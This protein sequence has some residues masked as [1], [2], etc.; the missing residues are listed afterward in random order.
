MNPFPR[1]SLPLPSVIRRVILLLLVCI[2]G[3]GHTQV[4][5]QFGEAA[6]ISEAMQP[7]YFNRDVT[8]MVQTLQLDDAQRVIVRTLFDD[9]Q[10]SFEDGLN[11]MKQRFEDMKDELQTGDQKRIMSMIFAPFREWSVEKGQ[12]GGNFL[13]SVEMILTDDQKTRWPS[14]QR[15]LFRERTLHKGRLSGESLNLLNVIRDLNLDQRTM[16]QVQ[17]ALD[18]YEIALDT[19]LHQRE[20]PLLGKDNPMMQSLEEQDLAKQQQALRAHLQRQVAVRNVNDEYIEH[21]AL[22]LPTD[23][24]QQFRMSALERAYPRIYRETPVQR[25][26]KVARDLEGLDPTVR[27][28]VLVL[29]MEY[30]GELTGVNTQLMNGTRDHEP[31]EALER[32]SDFSRRMAGEQVE[33]KPN[34]THALF[35]KREEMN[36]TYARRLRGL[37]TDEQFAQLPGAS[38]WVEEPQDENAGVSEGSAQTEKEAVKGQKGGREGKPTGGAGGGGG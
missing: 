17:P 12:L 27:Q 4:F 36:R 6:G 21:I 7:D 23:V 16:L 1:P 26:F 10:A 18:A 13:A 11:R 33:P 34:P 31:Q 3:L 19:A 38:R 20:D 14:V 9:Y 22:T 24:A 32:A 5:A 35:V 30:L 2:A 28:A 15:R 37:L 29:E 8:V 25:I